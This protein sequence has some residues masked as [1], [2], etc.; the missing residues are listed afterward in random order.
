[1]D[2][3]GLY[4]LPHTGLCFGVRGLRRTIFNYD[5]GTT[6]VR[7]VLGEMGG[8]VSLPCVLKHD[9]RDFLRQPY[10]PSPSVPYTPKAEAGEGTYDPPTP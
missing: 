3:K 6:V 7:V 5:V 10:I 2:C 8:T 4:E 9:S 1:M